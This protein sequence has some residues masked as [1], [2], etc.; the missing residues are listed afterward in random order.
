VLLRHLDHLIQHVGIERI[1]FGSD[2]DGA[3][4][5]EAIG[6]VSGL[7]S[8]RDALTSRGFSDDVMSKLCQENWIDVLERTWGA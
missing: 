7:G 8:L 2:F 6:D 5:P 3:K 1:G 4:V